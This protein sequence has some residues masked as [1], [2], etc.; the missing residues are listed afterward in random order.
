[1]VIRGIMEQPPNLVGAVLAP[2]L[3]SGKRIL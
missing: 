2:V 1:M 3:F